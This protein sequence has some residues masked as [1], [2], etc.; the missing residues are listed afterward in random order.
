MKR[1][2]SESILLDEQHQISL[3]EL[4]ELSD[5]SLEEL[6]HLVACGALVPDNPTDK[7][8]YFSSRC[9]VSIRTLCRL[10]NDFDLES[11]AFAL[12]LVFLERIRVLELKIREFEASNH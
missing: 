10:K 8:L 3:D 2:H 1:D 5:L 12:T 6:R 9:L 7:T 11:N 4:F